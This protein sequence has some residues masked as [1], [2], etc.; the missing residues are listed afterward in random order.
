MNLTQ[1]A[2][3]HRVEE[4]G[5][6]KRRLYFRKEDIS[7]KNIFNIRKGFITKEIIENNKML[8]LRI[9]DDEATPHR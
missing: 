7:R 4:G 5:K 8:Y 3:Q 2:T 9:D 1:N 6:K